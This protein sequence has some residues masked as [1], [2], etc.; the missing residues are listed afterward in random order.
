M[1]FCEYLV[2]HTLFVNITICFLV[3]LLFFIAAILRNLARHESYGVFLLILS[4]YPLFVLI[5][6]INGFYRGHLTY[7]SIKCCSKYNSPFVDDK[8]S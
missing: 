2:D 3:Q 4:I 7:K 5:I 8:K 1:D 6:I